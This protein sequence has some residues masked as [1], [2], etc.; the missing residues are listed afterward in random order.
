MTGLEGSELLEH[1]WEA[2]EFMIITLP[3][4]VVLMMVQSLHL[5]LDVTDIMARCHEAS[6]GVTLRP[7]R[8]DNSAKTSEE[9]WGVW[10]KN[11]CKM[12]I[13]IHTFQMFQP[14]F[15]SII[16]LTLSREVISCAMEHLLPTRWS[17]EPLIMR[18]EIGQTACKYQKHLKHRFFSTLFIA[19]NW[20]LTLFSWP[21][22]IMVVSRLIIKQMPMN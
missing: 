17:L 7:L 9:K 5:S 11:S 13:K 1:I 8:G 18:E 3:M 12:R 19:I 6:Q 20:F 21:Y 10:L 14:F 4:N 22:L 16:T 15:R 2:L